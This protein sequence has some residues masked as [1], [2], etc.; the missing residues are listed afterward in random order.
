MMAIAEVVINN[1]ND[2]HEGYEVARVCAGELW[3]Y[4][5]YP[6]EDRAKEVARE[7][8]DNAIIAKLTGKQLIPTDHKRCREEDCEE[9]V[10]YD[11]EV[12]CLRYK[13]RRLY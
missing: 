1:I 8:G 4:G 7:L 6:T 9:C 13:E 12:G 5:T 2:V 10:Y 11:Q 3:H